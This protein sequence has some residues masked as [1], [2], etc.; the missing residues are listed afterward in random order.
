MAHGEVTA[1]KVEIFVDG[2]RA[3]EG[4]ELRHHADLA[5]RL[6]RIFDHVDPV[7]ENGAG[8]G[9]RAGGAD[10]DGGG[11]SCAI[12]PQQAEDLALLQLQVDAIDGHHAQL[13]FKDFGQCFD[14]D[15]QEFTRKATQSYAFSAYAT[16]G[17]MRRLSR[18][19]PRPIA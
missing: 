18:A 15:N 17:T 3:V 9:Q 5:A 12:G 13:G 11:F 16:C 14:L 10:A 7:D 6:G 8:G 4:V 19:S 1:V 2:E